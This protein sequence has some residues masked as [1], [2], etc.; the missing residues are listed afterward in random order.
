[1]NTVY[2]ANAS[3]VDVDGNDLKIDGTAYRLDDTDTLTVYSADLNGNAIYGTADDEDLGQAGVQVDID[4]FDNLDQS[5]A[6]ITF[7]DN[8]ADGR[9]NVAIVTE[10][11]AA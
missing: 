1:D 11:D 2:T 4:A 5:I 10:Y 8:D 6:K 7:V 9:L 3:D